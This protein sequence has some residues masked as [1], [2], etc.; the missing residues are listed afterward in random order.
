LRPVG[1]A[2]TTATL[3]RSGSGD[4]SG[5]DSGVVGDGELVRGRQAAG[6]LAWADA[7]TALSLADRSASLAGDDLELLATAAYLLGHLED[8]LR[9][10]RRAQR[11]HAEHG[12]LRQAARC[13]FWL[14]FH[15]INERELAQAGGWLARAHPLLEQ[16]PERGEH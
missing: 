15:L 16:Q 1:R 10:L 7:Y 6:R 5:G 11:F 13:A 2:L 3:P 14:G 9:A 8:C 4:G 12:N